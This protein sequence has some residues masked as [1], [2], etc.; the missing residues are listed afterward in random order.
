MHGTTETV[1][2][3]RRRNIAGHVVRLQREIPTHAAMYWVQEDGIWTR[4]GGQNKTWRSTFKE[5]LEELVLAGMY[6]AWSPVTVVD[7]DFPS[8]D[9]TR[10]AGGPQ[11]K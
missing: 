6:P 10:G 4:G 3:T 9:A 2:K 1:S 11:S 7:V 5:D 8:P